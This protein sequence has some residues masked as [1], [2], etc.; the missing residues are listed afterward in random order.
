M[1]DLIKDRI[2]EASS[3][4]PPIWETIQSQI[5]THLLPEYLRVLPGDAFTQLRAARALALLNSGNVWEMGN[6]WEIIKLFHNKG[7]KM[8]FQNLIKNLKRIDP[9]RIVSNIRFFQVVI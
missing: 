1:I 8:K 5:L 3:H 4:I 9:L 2:D 6:K 7:L